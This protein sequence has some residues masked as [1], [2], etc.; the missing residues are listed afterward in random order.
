MAQTGYYRIVIL[1]LTLVRIEI[2]KTISLKLTESLDEKLAA[3]GEG[4]RRGEKERIPEEDSGRELVDLGVA[5]F[6]KL[7][8]EFLSGEKTREDGQRKIFQV[9]KDTVSGKQVLQIALPDGERLRKL[10]RLHKLSKP[11]PLHKNPILTSLQHP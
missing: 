11:P 6:S 4:S 10:N 5:V 7:A 2:M 1:V 9:I 3:G 8:Q